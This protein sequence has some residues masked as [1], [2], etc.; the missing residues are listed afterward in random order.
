MTSYVQFLEG[1]IWDERML[2]IDYDIVTVSFANNLLLSNYITNSREQRNWNLIHHVSFRSSKAKC[3]TIDAPYIDKELLTYF[4]MDINNN[5]YPDGG[6]SKDNRIFIY[7]HYPGQR[8][9]AMHTLNYNWDS[10]ENK[11]KS[12]WMRFDIKNVN[13][14]SRRNKHQDSCFEDWKRYDEYVMNKMM[15]KV[16]CRPIHWS[17]VSNIAICTNQSQMQK[18]EEELTIA[19]VES[20]DP[21]C[22]SIDQLDY[23]YEE[24]DEQDDTKYSKL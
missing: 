3:F 14:I 20:L 16:G 17:V 1:K 5:I 23:I 18:F 9:K 12:Y 11:T 6:R 8:F 21:P 24:F 4:R 7:I 10:R 13:V 22:R 19:M 2:A 15:I